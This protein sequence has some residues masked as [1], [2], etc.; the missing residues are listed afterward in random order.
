M[1]LVNVGIR[2]LI[3]VHMDVHMCGDQGLSGIFFV[4]YSA[5]NMTGIFIS[6]LNGVSMA[7]NEYRDR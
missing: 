4:L 5:T 6:L 2:G 7:L 3:C 1:C